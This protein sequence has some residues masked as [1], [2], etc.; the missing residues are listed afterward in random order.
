MEIEEGRTSFHFVEN[1]LWKGSGPVARQTTEWTELTIF[2]NRDGECSL[3][4]TNL[5]THCIEHGPCEA[6]RFSASQEIPRILRNPNVHYRIH[7]CPPPVPVLSQL[8]PVH[9][10]TFYF[11]KIH[12]N[13]ILPSNAVRTEYLN[14]MQVCLGFNIIKDIDSNPFAVRF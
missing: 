13:I 7:K 4:G 1:L 6:N 12:L 5:L 3:C 11:L 9:A 14:T 8:V 2:C 10:P